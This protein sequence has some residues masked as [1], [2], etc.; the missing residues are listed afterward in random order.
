MAYTTIEAIPSQEATI[1]RHQKSPQM[2][3]SHN[4][5]Q[6]AFLFQFDLQNH[7]LG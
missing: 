3:V 1:L 4:P 5:Q 6:T 7:E 2:P